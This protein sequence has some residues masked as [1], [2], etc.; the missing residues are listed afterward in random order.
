MLLFI[1]ADTLETVNLYILFILL[2]VVLLQPTSVFNDI[3]HNEK[4][5]DSSNNISVLFAVIKELLV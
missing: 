1:V 5:S 4:L 3:Y 2:L